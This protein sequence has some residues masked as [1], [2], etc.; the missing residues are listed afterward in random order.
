M[1]RTAATDTIK[2]MPLDASGANLSD[3]NKI[4]QRD[5][6]QSHRLHEPGFIHSHTDPITG[7]DVM[8]TQDHPFVVDGILTVYF[9]TESTRDDYLKT[10]YNRPV[11]R[12]DGIPSAEDD[13]GG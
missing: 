11:P 4:M 5:K 13:R 2:S 12:L 10:S 3:P 9:E 8:D 1:D 7:N 6:A